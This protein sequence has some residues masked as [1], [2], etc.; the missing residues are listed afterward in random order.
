MNGA[1]GVVMGVLKKVL[2]EQ[3]LMVTATQPQT[4]KSFRTLKQI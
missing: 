1:R 2:E 3:F 4:T